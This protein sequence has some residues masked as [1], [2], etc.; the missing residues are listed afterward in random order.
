MIE[1][2]EQFDDVIF[3]DESSVML[4]RHCWRCYCKKMPQVRLKHVQNIP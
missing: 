4:E 1:N 3:T 2:A